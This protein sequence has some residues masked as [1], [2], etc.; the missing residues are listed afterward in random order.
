[1]C[2]C[3]CVCVLVGVGGNGRRGRFDCGYVGDKYARCT[4]YVY[5]CVCV[6]VRA[7]ACV[8]V[9]V[10]CVQMQMRNWRV[11]SGGRS[12]VFLCIY[13]QCILYCFLFYKFI[14]SV[15]YLCSYE[16]EEQISIHL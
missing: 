9:C 10:W 7:R 4:E 2:V 12:R 1:M 3:V 5:V 8:R 16:G 6:C 11:G 14:Y 13:F 15:I